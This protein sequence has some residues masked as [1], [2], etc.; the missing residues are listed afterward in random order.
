MPWIGSAIGAGSSILGNLFGGS[1]AKK[2]AQASADATLKAAQI[3]ADAQRFRPVGVT[4]A[5]GSSNFGTD[6]QGNL[7]SAGYT[8]SPEMARQR[9]MLLQ[10]A[11]T[12]G[13]GMAEQAGVAGQGLFNLGQGYLAQSPEAAAQQ[14]MQRQ[15]A[16]LAPGQ[17]QALA[18][19]RNQQQ[20]QGRAGLAVGATTAGGMGASNPELQAYYNSLA[21]TNLDLAGKAQA[22][23][24]AQTQ[25]GTGLLGSGIDITSQGYNPYKTQFGLAQGLET[26]GQGALDIGSSLGGRAATAGANVGNTLFKGATSAADTMQKATNYS[27]FGASIAGL[28]S[29]PQLVS[30]VAGLFSPGGAYNQWTNPSGNPLQT[31]QFASPEFWT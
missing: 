19:I 23:G 27:P 9:D 16:A 6:A 3:A 20:Q 5:F 2:A 29:N 14:Y 7:T 17:E 26:A 8:L 15:Q 1:S 31:G 13:L 4:T 22:E 10:Q 30:G 21:Q 24:R 18:G 25:F 11:G 12:S 28:A